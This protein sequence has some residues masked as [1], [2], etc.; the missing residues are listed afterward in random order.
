MNEVIRIEVLLENQWV[1]MT[2]EDYFVYQELPSVLTNEEFN[3]LILAVKA[4]HL[5]DDISVWEKEYR[6]SNMTRKATMIE[7]MDELLM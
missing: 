1:E 7:E 6:C 4:K 5:L 2:P 3:K